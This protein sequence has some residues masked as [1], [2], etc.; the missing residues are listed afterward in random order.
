MVFSIELKNGDLLFREPC[1]GNEVSSAIQHVTQ[2]A[3]NYAFTHVGIV[4]RPADTDR[5]YVIEA[6]SPRVRVISLGEY[7]YPDTLKECKPIT[8]VGRLHD[9]YRSCIPDAIQEALRLV[10]KE[11][12]YGFVLDNDKYYCSELIYEIFLKA[13]GGVPVFKLN[14]MT[15][16][17]EGSTDTDLNWIQ[18]FDKKG[19]TIPEGE[20]GIN[21]GAMSRSDVLDLL[22]IL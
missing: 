15:F 22:G 10:G 21:P 12:D 19:L 7:L 6:A 17:Q 18:Y 5:I 2:S 11:Y 1:S 16:K 13:N 4:Y 20:P 8:I 9:Q 3:A 14:T